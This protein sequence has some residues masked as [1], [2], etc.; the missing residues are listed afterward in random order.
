LG[1]KCCREGSGSTAMESKKVAQS[2]TNCWN[3]R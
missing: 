1:L 2:G 3:E